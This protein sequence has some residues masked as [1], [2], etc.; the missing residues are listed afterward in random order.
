VPAVRRGVI[1]TLW[2]AVGTTACGIGDCPAVTAPQQQRAPQHL[3][4]T[5]LYHDWS[6]RKLANGVRTY[7]PRFALWA[8]GAVKRRFVKLPEGATIDTAD[9]NDWRFPVGTQLWKEFWRD[10]RI[11]ETRLLQ[12]YGADDA[13]WLMAA[14]VWNEARDDAT[15]AFDG[16]SNV[17]GTDHD[18]PAASDCLACH[19]GTKARVLGFSAIQLPATSQRSKGSVDASWDMAQLIADRRLTHPPQREISLPGSPLDQQALGYLHANCGSCHNQARPTR[20]PLRCYDP[21]RTLDLSLRVEQLDSVEDTP[22]LRSA[23]GDNLQ[24]GNPDDSAIIGRSARRFFRHMPPLAT[25]VVDERG[26]RLLESWVE[27]LGTNARRGRSVGER[28][29]SRESDG[30]GL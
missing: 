3:E 23:L 9:M 4:Q 6:S 13:D 29:D 14:Y 2:L 27:S 12:K 24:P 5:G 30:G 20:G 11:L 26:L 8:D 16:A 7:T 19:A 21:E 10:G 15:L 25:E 28:P 18:V 1:A 17:L 22:T